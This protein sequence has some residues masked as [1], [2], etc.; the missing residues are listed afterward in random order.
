MERLECTYRGD[1]WQRDFSGR[2]TIV[3]DDGLA[4]GS[5]MRAA[6]AALRQLQPARIVVAVPV[7]DA[8]TCARLRRE[9]DELVCLHTPKPLQAVGSLV[10]KVRRDVGS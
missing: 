6:V 9:V 8:D 10:R 2:I 7:G 3:V 4:T 1:A 5:T